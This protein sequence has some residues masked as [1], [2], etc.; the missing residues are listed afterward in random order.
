MCCALQVEKA[1]D[2][3]GTRGGDRGGTRGGTR[4]GNAS[5]NAW[6]EMIIMSNV[7]LRRTTKRYTSMMFISMATDENN[8]DAPLLTTTSSLDSF[9][10]GEVHAV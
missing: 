4:G 7:F 8:A 3:G 5:R 9:V 1:C 2:A 10:S 6:L